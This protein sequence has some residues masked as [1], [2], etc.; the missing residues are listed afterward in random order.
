VD[1]HKVG[2]AFSKG[3]TKKVKFVIIGFPKC[4]QVSIQEYFR[5]LLPDWECHR[6]E[7]IWRR[8]GLQFWEESYNKEWNVP[9]II[10]RNPVEAT[11]SAYWYFHYGPKW[12]FEDFLQIRKYHGGYGEVNPICGY[13]FE[14]WIKRWEKYDPLVIKLED[15]K[16][17]KDF[18]KYNTT[19]EA[20]PTVK[21]GMPDMPQEYKDM[22]LEAIEKDKNS[23]LLWS[24]DYPADYKF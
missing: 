12:K 24:E 17:W 5:K 18:P 6:P 20:R 3:S 23:K 14:K 2:Q 16:L 21:D 8:N 10:T 15:A 1:N 7:L 19:P 22:V 13:N 11:W 9:V 4:G